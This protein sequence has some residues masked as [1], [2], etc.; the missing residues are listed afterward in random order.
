MEMVNRC[1]YDVRDIGSK[2]QV[3]W[4]NSNNKKQEYE[5]EERYV[6]QASIIQHHV[7]N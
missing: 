4:K 1:E 7:N 2:L 3:P 5:N 6:K